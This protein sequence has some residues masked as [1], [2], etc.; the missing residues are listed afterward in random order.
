ML[1][2]M[3]CSNGTSK[4]EPVRLHAGS[5]KRVKGR[6]HTAEKRISM[7]PHKPHAT[8]QPLVLTHAQTQHRLSTQ[9]A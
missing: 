1:R 8:S 4:A 7:H 9:L 3:T 5:Y 6:S 2:G